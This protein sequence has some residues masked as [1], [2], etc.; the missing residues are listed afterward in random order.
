MPDN[1]VLDP[2]YAAHPD[3]DGNWWAFP[4]VVQH[5]DNYVQLE[6]SLAMLWNRISGNATSF[7]KNRPMAE[8]YAAAGYKLSPKPH[9]IIPETGAAKYY[10]VE[11]KPNAKPVLPQTEDAPEGIGL[12]PANA[13]NILLRKTLGK[14][15]RIADDRKDLLKETEDTFYGGG[16]APAPT[17]TPTP[18]KTRAA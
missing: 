8:S 6:P 9:V 17:P 3:K 12:L 14:A 11:P 13:V 4:T 16:N 10:Y 18:S 15:P 2:R 1:F 5:N 7:G